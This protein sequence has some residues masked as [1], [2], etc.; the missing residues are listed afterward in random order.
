MGLCCWASLASPLAAVQ[1]AVGSD[2][3]EPPALPT[4][5]RVQSATGS[6][7]LPAFQAR[8]LDR[9]AVLWCIWVLAQ[10]EEKKAPAPAPA[11]EPKKEE[12]KMEEPKKE[13]PKKEEPKKEEPKKVSPAGKQLL[14]QLLPQFQHA[15][16]A[17]LLEDVW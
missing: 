15:R 17:S 5:P 9:C 2:R 8:L 6:S 13:E 3:L 16:G 4:V 14:T 1:W 7:L 12:P 11:P 10:V